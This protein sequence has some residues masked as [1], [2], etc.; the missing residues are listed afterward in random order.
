MT[1][2]SSLYVAAV[3]CSNW[4][5]SFFMANYSSDMKKPLEFQP[6]WWDDLIGPVH[7]RSIQEDNHAYIYGHISLKKEATKNS[8]PLPQ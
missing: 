5:D 8:M 2:I 6:G 3:T 7:T 1:V 4:A